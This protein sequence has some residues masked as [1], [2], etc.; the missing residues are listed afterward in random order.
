[1]QNGDQR[2][3]LRFRRRRGSR[4]LI[5]HTQSGSVPAPITSL[6]F[7]RCPKALSL[8]TKWRPD[9]LDDPSGRLALNDRVRLVPGHVDPTCNLHDWYVVVRDGQVTDLWP[10]SARGRSW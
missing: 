5:A 7:R 1:M 4:F 2:S 6:I 8:K 10:V 9:E 3:K